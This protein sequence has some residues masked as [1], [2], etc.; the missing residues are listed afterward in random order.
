MVTNIHGGLLEMGQ[1]IY[2]LLAAVVAMAVLVL[3]GNLKKQVD[4]NLNIIDEME[5]KYK[6]KTLK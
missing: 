6:N 5:H 1:L 3:T 2:I 4:E